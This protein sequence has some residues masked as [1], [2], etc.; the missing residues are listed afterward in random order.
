MTS[1][2]LLIRQKAQAFASLLPMGTRS[3]LEGSR[4]QQRA[5]CQRV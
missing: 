4:E 1:S 3:S 5:L 2:D